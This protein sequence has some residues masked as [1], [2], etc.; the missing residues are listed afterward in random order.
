MSLARPDGTS[1]GVVRGLFHSTSYSPRDS[2]QALR[3]YRE[4]V[5]FC[6]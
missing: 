4:L 2:F 5:L 6:S 1:V 3:R